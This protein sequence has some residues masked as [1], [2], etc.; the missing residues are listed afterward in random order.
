M[1]LGNL[2]LP[3]RDSL[4]LD[5]WSTV[6]AEDVASLRYADLPSSSGLF[7]SSLLNSALTKMR[8]ASNDALIQRILHSPKIPRKS[9]AGLVKAESSSASS[10]DRGGTSPVVPW[11]QNQTS[12]ALSSSS[13]QQGQNRR[14]RK[15]KAP[16]WSICGG[17]A[18]KERL[19]LLSLCH[20]LGI[21]INEKSDLVPS[22]TANYLDMTMDTGAARIFPSLARVE[23][24]LSVAETFCA[25]SAPPA[26]LWQVVLGHLASLERLVPHSRLRIRSLQW[27][28]KTHWSPESDSPSLPVPLSQEVREDLSWWMVQDHLLKVVRFRTPAPDL[29]LYLDA[30]RSGWGAHL[31]DRV[32]SGVWSEQEKLLHINLL[33]MEA[34]FLALQSFQ[35]LVTGCHVTAMCDNLTVVAYINKQG[36]TVSRSLCSLAS[37]L[38]RWTE[39]LDVHLSARYLPGQSNVLADLLSRRDQIIWTE[40][41][42]H[43]QVARALPCRWSPPSIDQFATSLNAKLPLYCSL[44]LDPQAVFEDVFRHP[45][46]NLDLTHFH[47]FLCWKGGGSGQRDTQSLHDSGRPLLARER[48]VRQPSTSTDPTTSRAALVGPAVAAAPLQSVPPRRP[49]AEPSRVVTLQ[50]LLRKSGF[51]R[52]SAIEM[53]GYVRTSTSRLYQAKGCS[54]VVRVLEGA[55]LQLTPLFP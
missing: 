40:L 39:S 36:G 32:V 20:S 51:L 34:I 9:S 49:L 25:F 37:R 4:L 14:E 16:F 55:L 33:E 15:G 18:Q 22:Q 24:F 45:W 31:L 3:C 50:R 2:M 54:S 28:L 29:H 27:H 46:D 6:L 41:S 30:S 26:Q 7:P 38:L 5:V 48:V 17:R 35:E 1:A 47:P 53:F 44:V 43:S 13:T 23:K 21:V 8:A 10:A 11:S 19:D 12:T 42:L 52:G